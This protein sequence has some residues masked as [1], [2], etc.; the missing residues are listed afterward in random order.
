VGWLPFFH[1]AAQTA[2]FAA[3]SD[4]SNNRSRAQ[5]WATGDRSRRWYWR[6]RFALLRVRG[7]C[8]RVPLTGREED[9]RRDQGRRVWIMGAEICV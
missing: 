9:R 2:Y 4:M 7:G 5:Q 3:M 8:S 6:A 1:R